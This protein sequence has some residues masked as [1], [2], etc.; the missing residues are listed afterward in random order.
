MISSVLNTRFVYKVLTK[1]QWSFL[2]G[3]DFNF[4][5]GSDLDHRDKM[6]HLSKAEQIK[7]VAMKYF[8]QLRD[9]KLLKIQID[10]L[11]EGLKWEPNS[12]GEIFPHMYGV[13][14]KDAVV[15]V[16]DFDVRTFD[17]DSLIESSMS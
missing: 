3:A 2:D 8:P 1:E 9:G 7:P 10:K 17:Y 6:L 11:Q 14:K 15:E 12:K 13:I 5:K 4:E 16:F